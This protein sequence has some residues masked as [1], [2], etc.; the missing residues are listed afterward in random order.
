MIGKLAEY[1]EKDSFVRSLSQTISRSEQIVMDLFVSNTCNLHCKHCYFLDYR[2]KGD[3]LSLQK[4]YDIIDE[5]IEV[6]I[7]HFHFSGK[8]PFCDQNVP[9]L[10]D[11]INQLS[12][13]HDLRYGL[14]TNGTMLTTKYLQEL[15]DS[16]LS[17]IE[18]SLEGDVEFNSKVRGSNSF[19]SIYS[20]IKSIPNK[21]KLNITSTFFGDN[22]YDLENMI[23]KF[24]NIGISKFN[25]APYLKFDNKFLFPIDELGYQRMIDLVDYFRCYLEKYKTESIDIRICVSRRQAFDMYMNANILSDAINKYVFNRKKIVFEVG[26]NVLEMNFPLLYIPYLTQIIITNDGIII[27]CADDIHYKN[28]HEISIGEIS[29]C[30]MKSVMAKRKEFIFTYINQKIRNNEEDSNS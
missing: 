13:I 24:V 28:L 27:P 8:E 16:N 23:D 10:L 9:L 21:T 11:R 15:I 3:P 26:R 17:Y 4:W 6:G 1:I 14:V 30:N 19:D 20:L 2:P 25:I 5:S 7:R 12:R 22:N 29:N 18:F